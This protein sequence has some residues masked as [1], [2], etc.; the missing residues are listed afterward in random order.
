M[1]AF[2]G[3]AILATNLKTAL[4]SAF[5][6]RL[7]F[8]VN[9]PFP[10]QADRRRMWLKAFP[11]GMPPPQLDF[12]RL[13]RLDLTGGHIHTVALNAA[14][15]AAQA[16]TPVTM[17]L[18]LTAARDEFLKLERPINAADFTWEPDWADGRKGAA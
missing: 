18:V 10:S 9:F 4:D 15:L 3:L 13:V 8:V 2:G 7:R 11:P 17:P 16:G 12:D 1:E 6:R 5:L 14:F